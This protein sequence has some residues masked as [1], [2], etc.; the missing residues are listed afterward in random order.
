MCGRQRSAVRDGVAKSRIN[1][2]DPRTVIIVIAL[3][4]LSSGGLCYLI[5][6]RMP[7]HGG[8][9]AFAAGAMTFGAAY[10]ARLAAGEQGPAAIGALTDCAMIAGALLFAAGVRQFVDP[11]PF[12]IHAPMLAAVLLVYLALHAATVMHWGSVGRYVLLNASLGGLYLLLAGVGAHGLRAQDAAL[13][14]PLRLLVAL[15]G[16]L[17]LMTLGRATSIG[18]NGADA[19][20]T[21]LAAQVYFAYAALA[22][23]M[24]GPNLLWMVFLR[25][26]RQLAELASRDALTRTLNRNGLEDALRRHF[27]SRNQRT[28]A[29]LQVDI[30]H[31]KRVND[32]YGHH[33]GDRMLCEVAEVL[34]RLMRADDFVART[35]GEEFL[36]ACVDASAQTACLLAE[37]LR[38]GVAGLRIRIAG[39]SAPLQ[40]TASI[41]VSH[42]FSA[43]RQWEQAARKADDALYQA[44][45][46]GRNQV[47]LDSG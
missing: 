10:A 7:P 30:D 5:A 25:L 9:G 40:C 39:Q 44:K 18:L 36:V 32:Q 20:F 47:V 22:V 19:I 21:G 46:A 29:W 45:A 24:L 2:M 27:G 12:R 16:L 38:A 17:G 28:I 4:L 15:M 43:L 26:N 13:H 41:G 3:N 11:R 8:L 37:R 35:G 6:R 23:V 33:A 42:P 31:F 1:S 34:T 14:V